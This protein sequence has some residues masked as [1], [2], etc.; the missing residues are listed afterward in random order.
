MEHWGNNQNFVQSATHT[1]SSHGGTINHGGQM[2]YTAS[3]QMHTYGLVWTPEK[4]VFSVDGVEHYTYNPA[5]KNAETWPFDAEQFLLLNF[6][7]A[8]D[9]D[10]S[11]TQGAMEI[12]YVES[13]PTQAMEITQPT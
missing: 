8:E 9:I 4:L 3:S 12:D 10:P 7:I 5:A 13:I 1:P 2:I 11:F 6:A